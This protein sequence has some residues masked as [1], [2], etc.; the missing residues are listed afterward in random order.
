[1]TLPPSSNIFLAAS[2]AASPW[3]TTIY[4]SPLESYS[5]RARAGNDATGTAARAGA[6]ASAGESGVA[7][8]WGGDAEAWG[9]EVEGFGSTCSVGDG[10]HP[11]DRATTSRDLESARFLGTTRESR[12][13]I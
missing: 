6:F 10:P 13:V 2:V 12:R 5:S 1:M 11:T 7:E 3:V 4:S 8:A 9:G